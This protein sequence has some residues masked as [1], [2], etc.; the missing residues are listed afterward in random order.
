MRNCSQTSFAIYLPLDDD[1]DDDGYGMKKQKLFFAFAPFLDESRTTDDKEEPEEE[2]ILKAET[3]C[4]F[5]FS[6]K[7]INQCDQI[8]RNFATLAKC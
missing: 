2:D 7:F 4:K 3:S 8:W 5:L 6:L 1:N